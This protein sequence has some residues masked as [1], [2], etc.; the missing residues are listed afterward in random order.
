MFSSE[1]ILTSRILRIKMF[2]QILGKKEIRKKGGMSIRSLRDCE[3]GMLSCK[4][5]KEFEINTS[6]STKNDSYSDTNSLSLSLELE[7]CANREIFS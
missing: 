1:C 6:L 7:P 3:V 5:S 2:A 4:Q